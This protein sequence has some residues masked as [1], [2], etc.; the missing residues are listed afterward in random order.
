MVELMRL[1]YRDVRPVVPALLSAAAAAALV[2][3]AFGGVSWAHILAW[4]VLVLGGLVVLLFG[5]NMA[6]FLAFG[7]LLG[8]APT[9]QVPVINVSAVFALA[10]LVWIAALARPRPLP[11][12]QP[13]DIAFVALLVASAVSV[14]ATVDTVGSVREFV[15]WAIATAVVFPLR[16]LSA[17]EL[18]RVGRAFVAGACLAAATGIALLKLDPNYSF[19]GR[20]SFLGYDPMGGNGRFVVGTRGAANRLVGTYIDPN[21]GGFM[22]LIALIVAIALLSGHIRIVVGGLLSIAIALTLSR[23]AM[24]SAAV[25]AIVLVFLSRISVKLKLRLLA[26]G[27]VSSAGLLAIPAVRFR[28]IDSFGPTDT[29][30]VARR[31]AFQEFPHEMAGH[32]FFGNGWGLP[33]LIDAVAASASNNIANSPLLTLY[34]GGVVVAAVFVMMLVIGIVASW[35]LARSSDFPSAVIG[36]GFIGL[37]VVALQ[38]DFTVVTLISATMAFALLVAFVTGGAAAIDDPAPNAQS[39]DEE[40]HA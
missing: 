12:I 29:G 1:S 5:H 30:S 3:G 34:R 20:L 36:T 7:F 39:S 18:R 32:W 33:E 24:G 22:L 16:L 11:R 27:V 17:A 8:A 21:L 25:S 19:V 38:L 23:S 15:R 9:I 6:L 31:S 10:V 4:A 2:F 35:R 40:S 28:L 26:L 14:A 37:A 13:I